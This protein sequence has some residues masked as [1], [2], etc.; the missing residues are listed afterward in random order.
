MCLVLATVP[1]ESIVDVLLL[2]LREELRSSRVRKIDEVEVRD[3]PKQSRD[4]PFNDIDPPPSVVRR[5]ITDLHQ[6][7]CEDI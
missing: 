4:G 2:L 3:H 5:V 6:A 1:G 7:V